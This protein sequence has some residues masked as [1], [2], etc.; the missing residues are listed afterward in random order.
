MAAWLAKWNVPPVTNPEVAKW[1]DY[2]RAKGSVHADW[3]ASWRTWQRNAA[4]WGTSSRG[5]SRHVQP[6]D[7][8]APWLQPGYSAPLAFDDGGDQ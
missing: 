1:L 4:A 7:Y 5:G 8:S 6:V 2:H 3:G